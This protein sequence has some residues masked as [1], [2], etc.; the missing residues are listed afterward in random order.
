[1]VNHGKSMGYGHIY[2][3][4]LWEY[5]WEYVVNDGIWD[6]VGGFSPPL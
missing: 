5:L 4:Y 3:K 2:G 1:M 6:L